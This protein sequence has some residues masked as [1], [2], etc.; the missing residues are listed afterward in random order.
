MVRALVSNRE[1]PIRLDA[2]R[3]RRQRQRQTI[4]HYRRNEDSARCCSAKS[5]QPVAAVRY[6]L[7]TAATEEIKSLDPR[8]GLLYHRSSPSFATGLQNQTPAT[9]KATRRL[10]PYLC[11]VVLIFIAQNNLLHDDALHVSL[12]HFSLMQQ[13]QQS[14]VL[15]ATAA[16][17][18]RAAAAANFSGV[19]P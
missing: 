6:E 8:T 19:L 3:R 12:S 15:A 18:K 9:A 13:H 4:R 1:Q 16:H 2:L 14:K 7:T 17:S 11:V 10:Y 5:T